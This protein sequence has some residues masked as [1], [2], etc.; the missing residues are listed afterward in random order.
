MSFVMSTVL[1]PLY[2]GAEGQ[3]SVMTR[4][5]ELPISPGEVDRR[6]DLLGRPLAWPR[7]YDRSGIAGR[8]CQ[9]PSHKALA[10]SV[11]GMGWLGRLSADTPYLT[12]IALPMILADLV[13]REAGAL[14]DVDDREPAQHAR[15]VA[16]LPAGRAAPRGSA[17]SARSSGSA[18]C[19]RARPRPPRSPAAP[20][21]P[22]TTDCSSSRSRPKRRCAS[23]SLRSPV[24]TPR[25]G[26]SANAPASK[27]SLK[28]Q[29]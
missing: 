12:G 7:R 6:L 1:V 17:R 13:E 26:L 28:L 25:A 11:V 22:G 21:A 20:C 15:V 23:S 14:G 8:P 2:P 3:R 19:A 29:P 16:A 18:T 9:Y 27:P 24:W 5:V 4:L 10:I